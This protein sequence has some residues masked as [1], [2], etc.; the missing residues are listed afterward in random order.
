MKKILGNFILFIHL[1]SLPIAIIIII[2][3]KNF[4]INYLILIFLTMII[5]GWIL[6]G[7]CFLTPIENYL[8]DKKEIKITPMIFLLEE[9]LKI[10]KDYLNYFY[11]FIPIILIFIIL[12]KIYYYKKYSKNK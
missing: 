2:F 4:I 9:K 7:Y 10:P 1:I 3:F 6:L 11:T 12:V 8:F 5:I